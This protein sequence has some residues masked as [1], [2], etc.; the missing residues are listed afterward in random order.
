MELVEDE[1]YCEVHCCIHKRTIDP[2]DYGYRKGDEVE[3]LP[4][5]WRKLWIGGEDK[6]PYKPN[7]ANRV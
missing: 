2:Y 3:C 4:E 5:D 6:R 1:V 7:E